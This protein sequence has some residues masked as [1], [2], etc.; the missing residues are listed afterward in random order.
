MRGP[1]ATMTHNAS[2]NP[3]PPAR[4]VSSRDAYSPFLPLDLLFKER[5]PSLFV[6]QA[7]L[8][9][10]QYA[11]GG[12]GS[13]WVSDAATLCSGPW[14]AAECGVYMGNSLSAYAQLVRRSGLQV[15]ILGLDTFSG[16]PGLSRTD[17][18]LAPPNAPYRSATLFGDTSLKAV[19][20]MVERQGLVD[21]ISLVPGLFRD[22]LPKL[23][24]GPYFFVNVDCDL[25][26]PHLECLQ[27]FYPRV[28]PGG[29]I[30]LDDYHSVEY[31]MARQA[32]DD[33]MRDK[34]ERL[35]HLRYGDDGRNHTKAFFV[36]F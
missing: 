8:A 32:V 23:P 2:T 18:E 6:F 27:F 19:Q 29:I 13:P 28:C 10:L 34:Q 30:Y 31:P 11:L 1:D 22:T 21:L 4:K 12:R 17:E 14:L 24:D 7:A 20:D 36:K 16:L 3:A 9:N 5:A 26:E 33:F 25:Y 35:F 15:K